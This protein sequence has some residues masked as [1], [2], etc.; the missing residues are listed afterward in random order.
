MKNSSRQKNSKPKTSAR[1]ETPKPTIS[2]VSTLI[3]KINKSIQLNVPAKSSMLASQQRS[4]K[5][6]VDSLK[7]Y[8]PQSMHNTVHHSRYL[9]SYFRKMSITS[10]RIQV[11]SSRADKPTLE[12]S[13][14]EERKEK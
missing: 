4:S 11:T 5:P 12:V 7:I 9:L 1:E 3:N 13:Q 8:H 2:G 14:K 6:K 10:A